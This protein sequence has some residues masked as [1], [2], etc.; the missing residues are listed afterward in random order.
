MRRG[1][2]RHRIGDE[3]LQVV[4]YGVEQQR[5]GW[6]DDY[7][8]VVRIDNCTVTSMSIITKLGIMSIITTL[9]ITR[10]VRTRDL[11]V[12]KLGPATS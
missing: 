12:Q 2:F 6:A 1:G 3:P 7:Y 8:V 4:P 10:M 5:A 9:R 11:S